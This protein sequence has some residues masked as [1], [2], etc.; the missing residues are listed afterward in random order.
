MYR[1]KRETFVFVRGA[2]GDLRTRR[3]LG[4]AS[5]NAVYLVTWPIQKT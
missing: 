5:G 1:G 4:T 3:K 2:E